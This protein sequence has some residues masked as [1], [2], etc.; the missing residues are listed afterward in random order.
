MCDYHSGFQQIAY[1]K[2][3]TGELR[4]Q[5]LEHKEEA[6]AYTSLMPAVARR[7]SCQFRKSSNS[8]SWAS[9]AQ[10]SGGFRSTP[11]TQ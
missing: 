8:N 2:T 1:V 9:L 11:R 3:D 5:R 7:K 4:E 6:R 10:N